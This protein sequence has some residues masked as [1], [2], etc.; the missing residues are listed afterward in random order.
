MP[1]TFSVVIL[2]ASCSGNSA[3][4]QAK[5]DADSA[6]AR[7]VRSAHPDP[8]IYADQVAEAEQKM[9][10]ST[11]L[12]VNLANRA[13][14]AYLDFASTFPDDSRAPD[15][16]FRAGGIAVAA[17][18]YDQ[19]IACYDHIVQKYPDYKYVVEALYQEAM[20]YDSNL[21]GQD[22]KARV[23]YEQLIHDYPKNKLADDAK[24]AI[25]HLGKTDEEIVKEFEA[26]NKK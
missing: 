10:A 21:P 26:K 15:Y 14:K 25:S 3:E 16:Y 12:D 7:A 17:G 8:R 24:A 20:I 18:N 19:G 2:L 13:I 5:A 23:L 11:T 6:R 1:L 9:K 4:K 22:E